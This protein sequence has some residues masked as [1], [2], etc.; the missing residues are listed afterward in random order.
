MYCN[1]R[2]TTTQ[3]MFDYVVAHHKAISMPMR[4]ETRKGGKPRQYHRPRLPALHY[5]CVWILHS[6]E[7]QLIPLDNERIAFGMLAELF[8]EAVCI[9]LYD[10]LDFTQFLLKTIAAHF[11]Q[12]AGLC[13]FL[14]C[15]V[16]SHES[17][18]QE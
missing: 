10:F 18:Q 12:P 3:Q 17:E 7:V 13:S 14:C 8:L 2:L 9:F 6:Y 16:H 4:I 1:E 5:A 11:P 15:H